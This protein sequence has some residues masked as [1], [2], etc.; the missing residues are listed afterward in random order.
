MGKN[1]GLPPRLAAWSRARDRFTLSPAQVQMAR[2]LGLDPKRLGRLDRGDEDPGVTVA[3][4]IERLYRD[5]FDR[6]QPDTVESLEEIAA[7]LER[8]KAEKRGARSAPGSIPGREKRETEGG[9][10][11][12]LA[13]PISLRRLVQELEAVMENTSTYLDKRTGEFYTLTDDLMMLAD[14]DEDSLDT[15]SA[16][17]RE[18]ADFVLKIDDSDRYLP[19]PDQWEINELR[20]LDRFAET[21]EDDALRAEFRRELG[22]RGVFRRFRNLIQRHDLEKPWDDF[23]TAAL[24]QLARDWLE[25][26]GLPF[27]EDLEEEG[28]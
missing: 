5:T 20:L 9:R 28:G 4:R 17:E 11:V 22:G 1:H 21:L 16:W 8:K 14:D 15:L 3:E 19:I 6:E 27:R 25:E 10:V 24:T 23:E 2:D 12:Q 7:R 18:V 13:V 26:N